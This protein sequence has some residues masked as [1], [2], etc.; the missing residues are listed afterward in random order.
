MLKEDEMDKVGIGIISHAHGHINTYCSVM[1]HYDDVNLVATWD[2]NPDRAAN[3]ARSFGLRVCATPEEVVNDPAVDA[4][5]IGSETNRHADHVELAA[6]AGKHILLQK[7]MATTLE[8]CDRI[9]AAVQQSG[10]KFTL[11]YQMRHDPVNRK[12]KQLLDEGAV[13]KIALVRRRHCI[14]VLLDQG[15]VTGPSKWHIDPVA[16]I[17]MFFDDASHAADWFYWMLG[18]PVSVMAEVGN[19]VTDVAADDNGVAVYRFANGEMGILQNSS[20]TVAA[21]N[22]TEIY[23]DSGTIIQDWGDGPSSFPPRPAGYSPLRLWQ[24]G[25]DH[26]EEFDLPSPVNHGERIAAVP[27]PFLQYVR[28]LTEETVSAEEG[29]ISVEMIL[30]AYSSAKDGKR[31]DFAR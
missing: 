13:G 29:R 27:R 25:N 15:F 31:I 26:W 30:A 17:G 16:N 24:K 2:D 6:S 20:T 1:Q 19:V 10:V 4:V 21:V 12:M 14:G 8:D 23:G 22:T 11:A 5:M 7:P 3:A 9:I 28:G 18:R